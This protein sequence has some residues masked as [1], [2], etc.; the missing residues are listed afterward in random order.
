MVHRL[1][2]AVTVIISTMTSERWKDDIAYVTTP[3]KLVSW[4]IGVWPLQVYNFYLLRSILSACFAVRT[5]S[6][7]HD[8]HW[9][10]IVRRQRRTSSALI[11]QRDL[12]RQNFYIAISNI[13]CTNFFLFM[14]TYIE[15]NALP[16]VITQWISHTL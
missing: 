3:Y 4:P 13:K 1:L 16:A 2:A 10:A 7:E 12:A 15:W 5:F 6:C 14:P 9:C 11:L 8:D